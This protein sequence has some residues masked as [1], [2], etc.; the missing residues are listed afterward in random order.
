MSVY[1]ATKTLI[2]FDRAVRSDQ[3]ATYRGNLQKVL[4]HI[5]DAYRTEDDGF[6]SHLGASILGTECER[7][8]WYS[9]H[10]ASKKQ[11]S[12][13]MLRLFNRGHLE[14]GRF[15][16]LLLSIGC[17]VYQQDGQGKQYRISEYG[18]H[19]GGSG[20]G[21][22]IDVPDLQKGQA[23]L[24]EFKTHNDKSFAKL[25]GKDWKA[26]VEGLLDPSK[27]QVQFDGEG[28]RSAK[29]EH[30]VQMQSYMR[31]MG[32]AVGLYMAVNKNDDHIYA[33]LVPLDS[34]SADKFI[35]RAGK[36]IMMTAA[37][38]MISKS[39][40]WFGCKFCD[41]K[42]VCKE[43]K[44]VER[45][46]RTCE[47]ASADTQTGKWMCDN[48]ERQMQLLFPDTNPKNEDFSLT[49]ERQLTGC[50]HYSKNKSM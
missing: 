26:Y 45:N 37:P 25:A 41:F 10:W 23:A 38:P 12:G 15:I 16:A 2:A 7:S 32:L 29:F 36:V 28:V 34:A 42:P 11:F 33:E 50:E 9:F 31:K 8:I 20:D 30:W 43:G 44:Q 5:G 39:P 49:K 17:Q 24:G 19:F 46:C 14:E 4:P 18:G 22:V 13:Q 6:R 40:G 35:E 47:F 21:V 3:G 27:P 48:K 1:I